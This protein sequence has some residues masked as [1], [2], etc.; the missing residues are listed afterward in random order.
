MMSPER[1]I[2]DDPL[3]YRQGKKGGTGRWWGGT[4][5]QAPRVG[6]VAQK[7]HTNIGMGIINPPADA[8]AEHSI[9]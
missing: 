1:I 4:A 9:A 5:W 2:L 7:R 6:S 3:F 8:T